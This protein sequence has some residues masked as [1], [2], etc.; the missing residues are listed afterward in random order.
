MK[1]GETS[2]RPLSGRWLSPGCTPRRPTS[3]A[4]AAGGGCGSPRRA[5][6]SDRA[7]ARAAAAPPATAGPSA[8]RG[9]RSVG[10]DDDREGLR[11]ADAPHAGVYFQSREQFVDEGLRLGG[12]A[13]VSRTR[14][15]GCLERSSPHTR[16][17]RRPRGGVF[18]GRA[19]QRTSAATISTARFTLPFVAA[20]KRTSSSSCS[21]AGGRGSGRAAR[22]A[23]RGPTAS[24]CRRAG[25]PS[26]TRR[27]QRRVACE[28]TAA[29]EERRVDEV[30][31]PARRRKSR[32]AGSSAHGSYEEVNPRGAS[33]RWR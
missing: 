9:S 3:G 24:V 20:R 18:S 27:W 25:W 17:R 23:P 28:A 2:A 7:A 30:D 12:D 32:P 8:R 1:R 11:P 10:I 13:S 14:R 4:T 33:K 5:A 19:R 31:A 29:R 22:S 6:G 16:T 26:A 15:H 21:A